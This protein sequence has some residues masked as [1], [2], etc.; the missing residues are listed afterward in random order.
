MNYKQRFKDMPI[1][2]A[3]TN[4]SDR[5]YFIKEISNLAYGENTI[6]RGYSMADVIEVLKEYSDNALKWELGE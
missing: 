2:K 6:E 3:W 4:E 1:D 5:E